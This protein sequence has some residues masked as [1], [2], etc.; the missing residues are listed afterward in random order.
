MFEIN[1]FKSRRFFFIPKGHYSEYSILK[2]HFSEGLYPEGLLFWKFLSR[3]DFF[4]IPKGRYSIFFQKLCSSN[5]LTY[6]FK[7]NN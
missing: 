1:V 6:F 7:S 5:R 4:L 2:G 3:K